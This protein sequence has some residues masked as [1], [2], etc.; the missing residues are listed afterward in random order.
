ML[1]AIVREEIP[2]RARVVAARSGGGGSAPAAGL[3]HEAGYDVVGVTLKTYSATRPAYARSCCGARDF[4]DARRSA[5]ILGIPHYVLDVEDDFRRGVIERFQAEYASG[6]TPNPC[7]S[8]NNVVKLG[9]LADYAR[10]LG[11]RYV[12]TGHYARVERD[13]AG[14]HLHPGDGEKD[15]SYALAQ[16]RREQL[17]MLL[18]P[19]GSSCKDAT[20]AQARRLRLPVHDKPDSQEICFVEG[21]DY[22]THVGARTAEGPIVTLAGEH[23]GVHSGVTGFTVGQRRGLPAHPHNDGPRYVTRIDP[24]T[25]AIVIG[26]AA[27]LYSRAL[28]ADDVSFLRP[29]RF[30]NGASVAVRAMTRYR[31]PLGDADARY[32]AATGDLHVAFAAPERAVAPGQ[33]VAL[34]D[35]LSGEVLGG[36]TIRSAHP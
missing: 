26:R 13:D 17:E 12:A 19:I 29:E 7:I 23:V 20:R 24:A 1:A 22:R 27:D 5:A 28:V 25:N 15:Q 14:A 9:T 6:R 34:Y 4:D 35:R 21:G 2:G 32:D 3:R 33:A 10:K 8:C 31:S 30:A 16:L 36:A 18:L 11:A